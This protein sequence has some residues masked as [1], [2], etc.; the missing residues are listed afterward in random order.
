MPP[1]TI[2]LKPGRVKVIVA[3][4]ISTAGLTPL[5]LPALKQKTFEVMKEL[6]V[7]NQPSKKNKIR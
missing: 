1:G 3:P 4:E 6:I 5:D 2:R 7:K